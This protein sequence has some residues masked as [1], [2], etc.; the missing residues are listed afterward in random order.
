MKNNN[1]KYLSLVILFVFLMPV[2]LFANNKI[3]K[4]KNKTD[5]SYVQSYRITGSYKIGAINK[6]INEKNQIISS[7]TLKYIEV[8]KNLTKNNEILN[9]EK[10]SYSSEIDIYPNP[11]QNIVNITNIPYIAGN[12]SLILANNEGVELEK[13][14]LNSNQKQIDVSFLKSGLYFLLLNNSECTQTFKFIKQ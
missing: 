14:Q 12:T 6:Q 1:N 3:I 13:Y 7:K 5:N 4:E 11:T 2:I 8:K 9:C 10:N